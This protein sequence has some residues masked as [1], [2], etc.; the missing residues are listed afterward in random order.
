MEQYPSIIGSAKAP[1]GKPCIAQYKYD[2]SNLRFEWSPKQGW[3]K[4]GTR[5]HLFDH[6][7][8]TFGPAI[9]LFAG[10]SDEILRRTRDFVKNPQRITAF[11]EFFGEHS[12]AGSHDPTDAKELRLFDVFL[13][14]KGM[15]PVKDFVKHYGDM[16]QAA[17]IVY[18]G[19]LNQQFIMDL[20][21]GKFKEPK[22][23]NAP[24]FEGVIAKGNGFA[25]KIKTDAY[26]VR[27]RHKYPERWQEFGE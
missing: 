22:H 6:T 9:E 10:F 8:P 21:K 25:V 13:F 27:L 2:G 23:L 16:P 14:Q 11:A 26:F 1:L 7:D 19:N 12:F 15:L 20:K 4:F 3:H 18:E 24:I 5:R 17:E